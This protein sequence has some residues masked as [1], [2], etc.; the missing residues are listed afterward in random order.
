MKTK[1]WVGGILLLFVLYI[2]MAFNQAFRFIST[3][4]PQAQIM[5]VA[6][7]VVP[8]FAV[9]IL[10][11]EVLFGLRTE[12]MGKTLA[13]LGE[14]PKDL[15]RMPSGRFVREAA[16]ADFPNHQRDVEEHPESW[17]SWY[18]L[19]LAYEASGDKKRARSSM[20]TA[21]GFWRG[22]QKSA[23]A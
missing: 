2:A 15:P 16:D 5:G 7:F 17:K 10:I 22:E 13:E 19:A 4:V 11:R 12:K 8:A 14:L 9:W 6:I 21:I 23:N 1:L 18:R 20:R 3:G